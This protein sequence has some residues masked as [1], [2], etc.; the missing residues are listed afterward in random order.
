MIVYGEFVQFQFVSCANSLLFIL[1][2]GRHIYLNLAF[3]NMILLYLPK[4]FY[5]SCFGLT[6]I[7]EYLV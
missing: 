3:E 7:N 6:V 1:G 4:Y 5:F 2:F